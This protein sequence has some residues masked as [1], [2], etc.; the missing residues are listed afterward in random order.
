MRKA[1]I[2]LLLLAIFYAL[3]ATWLSADSGAIAAG[4]DSSVRI[5]TAPF[6]LKA[7]TALVASAA[8]A[9]SLLSRRVALAARIALGAFGLIAL[10]FS[11]HV[12]AFNYKRGF[13]EEHWL[14][15][16]RD[17]AALNAA[18]GLG[19][20]WSIERGRFL[21]RL[22]NRRTGE[23]TSIFTGIPPLRVER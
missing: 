16:R 17:V 13:V 6:A 10:A 21:L 7:I 23:R 14:L 20:D 11:T 22:T 15:W 4:T 3:V 5:Y 18:D 2:F 19:E 9:V 1:R 8:W 12:I